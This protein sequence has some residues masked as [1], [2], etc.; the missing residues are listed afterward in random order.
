MFMYVQAPAMVVIHFHA[1]LLPFF[2]SCVL[3][4]YLLLYGVYDYSFVLVLRFLFVFVGDF[5]FFVTLFLF[6]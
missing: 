2:I 6:C 3:F 1:T 5:L 4:L